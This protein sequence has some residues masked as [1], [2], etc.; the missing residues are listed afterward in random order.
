[1]YE[2]AK[3]DKMKESV[4]K[5]VDWCECE[6]T[7]AYTVYCAR[8][9]TPEILDHF[10]PLTRRAHSACF[11]LFLCNPGV[12]FFPTVVPLICA[13]ALLNHTCPLTNTRM[14]VIVN[15]NS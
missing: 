13:H 5:T 7:R 6:L 12:A 9:H 8:L 2:R 3:E 11:L 15:P 1:M 4:P 14:I 10:S